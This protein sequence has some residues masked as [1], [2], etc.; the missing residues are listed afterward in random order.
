MTTGHVPGG[1]SNQPISRVS[2]YRGIDKCRELSK[3]GETHRD[4][5]QGETHAT[6]VLKTEKY[7]SGLSGT[8]KTCKRNHPVRAMAIYRQGQGH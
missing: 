4:Q 8:A 7:R 2:S 6:L 1:Q 3:N 5:K